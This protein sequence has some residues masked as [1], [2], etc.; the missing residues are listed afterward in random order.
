[1]RRWIYA[2]ACVAFL[3]CNE[4]ASEPSPGDET[5]AFTVT[6]RQQD[7]GPLSVKVCA[8]KTESAATMGR[9]FETLG[10]EAPVVC[11]G[12]ECA[13]LSF[14]DDPGAAAGSGLGTYEAEL[15]SAAGDYVVSW[16]G[17]ERARASMPSG[18]DITSPGE[19]ET[20][21]SPERKAPLRW[22]PGDGVDESINYT[23][24]LPDRAAARQYLSGAGASPYRIAWDA[25]PMSWET[26]APGE[27]TVTLVAAV[28][29]SD[30]PG[31]AGP[32]TGPCSVAVSVERLYEGVTLGE[33]F[34][35]NVSALRS[36]TVAFQTSF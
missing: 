10:A 23:P 24:C 3:A 28:L 20:I 5:A 29:Q 31:T 12:G 17:V 8:R 15:V 22:S 2:A 32:A 26:T 33:G 9:C 18:F 6:L 14:R 13:P 16:G 19:G 11:H 35:S 34:R 1:M 7:D 30:P 27:A 21:A 36:R 25:G 4:D